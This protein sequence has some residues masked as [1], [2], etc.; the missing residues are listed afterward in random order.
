MV[1]IC[2]A[3]GSWVG[4]MY[5]ALCCRYLAQ[6]GYPLT[7]VT[8]G[9]HKAEIF[10]VVEAFCVAMKTRNLSEKIVKPARIVCMTPDGR[11]VMVMMGE[12]GVSKTKV[13]RAEVRLAAA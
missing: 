13:R 5:T 8:P 3:L 6:K 1:V 4:G 2:F 7:L 12:A 11:C 9:N 10:R